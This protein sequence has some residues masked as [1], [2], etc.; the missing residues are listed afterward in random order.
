MA[1]LRAYFND[2][3]LII[4]QHCLVRLLGSSRL[5]HAIEVV[6]GLHQRAGYVHVDWRHEAEHQ[7]RPTST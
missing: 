2:C 6:K 3:N 7:S 5:D 1:M 4:F